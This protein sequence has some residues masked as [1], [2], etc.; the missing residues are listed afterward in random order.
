METVHC[1][2]TGVSRSYVCWKILINIFSD[3]LVD[4]LVKINLLHYLIIKLIGKIF[5]THPKNNHVI[6]KIV[7]YFSP[8]FSPLKK[9]FILDL[10]NEKLTCLLLE[11]GNRSFL[12]KHQASTYFSFVN[13]DNYKCLTVSFPC[14]S[15]SILFS[16]IL[17]IRK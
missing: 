7:E 2:Q 17:G 4:V 9:A 13:E 8:Y 15:R 16:L 5:Y 6:F 10:I 3:F 1:S 11:K 12:L 14:N